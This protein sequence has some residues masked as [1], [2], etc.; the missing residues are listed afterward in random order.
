[1]GRIYGHINCMWAIP[2][3]LSRKILW[4]INIALSWTPRSSEVVPKQHQ[5]DDMAVGVSGARITCIL[6]A[7]SPRHFRFVS[8]PF[9]LQWNSTRFF[10]SNT[11]QTETQKDLRNSSILDCCSKSEMWP[12]RM[13]VLLWSLGLSLPTTMW[14][15]WRLGKLQPTGFPGSQWF[16]AKTSTPF[17]WPRGRVR[18]GNRWDVHSPRSW[19]QNGGRLVG[20]SDGLN[21]SSRKKIS[22]DLSFLEGVSI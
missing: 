5:R 21:H 22:N 8:S 14:G 18:K 2:H 7:Q 16:P 11:C 10:E 4:E 3:R 6:S 15:I 20:T 1:M 13:L 17:P 9:Y 19:Y 12:F